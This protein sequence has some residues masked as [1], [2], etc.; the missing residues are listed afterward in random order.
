M[1][2]YK[3]IRNKV[4]LAKYLAYCGLC[5]RRKAVILIKKGL[6]K[7]N[8]EVIKE[9]TYFVEPKDIIKYKNKIIKPQDF[10]YTLLNK[11]K[12]YITTLSDEKG[13][14]TVL[15]LIKNEQMQRIYPVGRLDRN[16]TGLL[17][18]TNDGQLA[19]KLSHPKFGISKKYHVV[20]DK[21]F[22]PKD[23][24]LLK[25]G[26][27]LKD[28]FI[29]P[30]KLYYGRSLSKKHIILQLHSGKNL[31]VRRI[32]EHLGYK[33]KKLDRVEYAGLTKKGLSQGK[34]RLLTKKEIEA[35]KKRFKI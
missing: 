7:V 17:L 29:K 30:D 24:E 22:L 13:R 18:L 28:G 3:I 12:N 33:I 11:P 5:S 15:D 23:F 8:E 6:I 25:K 31:I 21:P 19:Q 35:L 9:V 10:I 27:R 16:T 20:L 32:F 2:Y 1:H 26:L 34:W 14:K 4:Y